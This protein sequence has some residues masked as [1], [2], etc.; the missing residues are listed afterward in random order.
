M[1]A[2]LASILAPVAAGMP[3]PIRPETVTI[4]PLFFEILAVFVTTVPD[5]VS[6]FAPVATRFV[7]LIEILEAFVF[8]VPETTT[9]LA[10]VATRLLVF[11]EMFDELL[12]I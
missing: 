10:P 5:R 4:S 1:S 12:V 3:A 8:A 11:V 2:E 7:V 9:I 6:I